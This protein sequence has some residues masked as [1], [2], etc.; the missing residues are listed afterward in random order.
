MTSATERIGIKDTK[1]IIVSIY[2]FNPET[3]KK[4]YM[5]DY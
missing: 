5:H 1:K 2:R 4:P 3:D